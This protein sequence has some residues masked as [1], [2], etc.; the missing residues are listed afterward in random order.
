MISAVQNGNFID[1]SYLDMDRNVKLKKIPISNDEYFVWKKCSKNNQFEDL[2]SWDGTPINK[3]ITKKLNKF[4]ISEILH[5]LDDETQNEIFNYKNPP[6]LYF[7]DIE[8][9]ILEDFPNV[10]NPINKIT[11]VS[12]V[13]ERRNCLVL[14]LKDLSTIKQKEIERDMELYF[15]EYNLD[16]NFKYKK[17]N[18]EKEMLFALLNTYVRKMS[19]ITGWNFIKF[20]WS[21]ILARSRF[22]GLSPECSSIT[23]SLDYNGLPVH[24]VVFDYLEMYK[25]PWAHLPDKSSFKL[26]YIG[27]TALGVKKISYDGNLNDLYNNDFKK[28]VMYNAVD[29]L[30]VMLL[31]EN[32]NAFAAYYKQAEQTPC[33][34]IA[35]SF[36]I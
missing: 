34:E 31:H 14:G 23:N 26:D 7:I 32:Y 35:S 10:D 6:K 16:I 4:R 9:E 12:I 33:I 15:K 1:V 28:F 19:A 27:E 29:S 13:D 3:K 36:P 24:K 18:S 22:V 8:T 21:Y 2:K 17:F 11:T 5:N 30:L 25:H 20:D